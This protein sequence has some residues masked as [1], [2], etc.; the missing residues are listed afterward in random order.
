MDVQEVFSPKP[1]AASAA[2]IGLDGGSIGGFLC[3]TSGTVSLNLGIDGS[4]TL[5][6][7]AVPVTAGVFLPMPFTIPPGVGMYATLAG[8]AEGTFAIN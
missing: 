3:T 5:I 4:G 8:G 7:D 1:L 6:V 2:I